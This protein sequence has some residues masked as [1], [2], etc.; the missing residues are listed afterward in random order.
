MNMSSKKIAVALAWVASACNAVQSRAELLLSP[1]DQIVGG[2]LTGNNFVEGQAGTAGG[3]NNWPAAEPPVE[4]I[5]GSYGG[6]GA[7]YLN[8]FELNTGVIITPVAGA[9]VVTSMTLWTANDAEARDPTSYALYGT[10]VP[11]IP[12]GPGATYAASAFTLISSG[13]VLL[14]AERNTVATPIGATPFSV[15]FRQTIEIAN[16]AS[17]TS[18]MLVFPT[19]KDAAAANSMQVSEAAF[20][21][22][23]GTGSPI[24]ITDFQYNEG[25]DEFTV[26]WRSEPNRTYA[27]YYS[28]DLINW[29]ADVDDNIAGAT[30][31]ETTTYGPF[32]NPDS[33]GPQGFFRVLRF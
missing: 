33:G 29:D 28:P 7:K 21:G 18:Y 30:D 26:T 24:A 5:D 8:F 19:V 1:G 25:T 13:P 11:V 23:I 16:S 32:P 31:S 27:L 14:P 10:N 4:L 2:V 9:T 17:F 3:V 22:T 12:G 15:G 20:E 6:D